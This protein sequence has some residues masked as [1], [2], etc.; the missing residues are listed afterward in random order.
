MADFSIKVYG[1]ALL[2]TTGAAAWCCVPAVMPWDGYIRHLRE[3]E[4]KKKLKEEARE[5]SELRMETLFSAILPL[6][7]CRV[8]MLWCLIL[9][10][11]IPIC[12]MQFS[13]QTSLTWASSRAGSGQSVLE[14]W[15]TQRSERQ[16]LPSLLFLGTQPVPMTLSEAG[17]GGLWFIFIAIFPSNYLPTCSYRP[18]YSQSSKGLSL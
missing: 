10:S 1:C 3:E 11:V 16:L 9:F 18:L 5:F 17:H 7:C 2:Q 8:Q 14:C 15:W 12:M 4:K 6:R 13:G